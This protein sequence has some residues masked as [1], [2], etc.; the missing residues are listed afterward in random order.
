MSQS[1]RTLLRTTPRALPTVRAYH[2]TTLLQIPYK[3]S[4]DRET[5]RPGSTENTRS[6]R[7]DEI[8][9]H[10]PDA[11]FNPNKTSPEEAMESTRQSG[12]DKASDLD[13]SGA[14]QKVNKPLGDEKTQK[15]T[16]AGK[17]TQKGGASKGQKAEKGG[18]PSKA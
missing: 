3:N 15:K 4:Q 10:H 18:S 14:D 11:A 7:D 17:E 2:S 5:V 6:A 16:G 1:L 8:A 13:A 9:T 12:G